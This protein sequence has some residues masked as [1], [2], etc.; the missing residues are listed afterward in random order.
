MLNYFKV[1]CRT[2]ARTKIKS[3]GFEVLKRLNN[4]P[5]IDANDNNIVTHD[6]ETQDFASLQTIEKIHRGLSNPTHPVSIT[7]KKMQDIL[8]RDQRTYS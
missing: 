7:M 3:S 4:L 6:V 5:E 1:N 8:A 2:S